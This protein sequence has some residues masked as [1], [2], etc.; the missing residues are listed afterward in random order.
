MNKSPTWLTYAAK[1]KSQIS[2]LPPRSQSKGR[3]ERIILESHITARSE[4]EYPGTLIDWDYIVANIE[5]RY[6]SGNGVSSRPRKR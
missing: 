5:K 3:R 2:R 4:H 1:I 6:R